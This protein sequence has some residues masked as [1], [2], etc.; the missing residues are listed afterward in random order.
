MGSKGNKS[1]RIELERLYGKECFIKKLKLREKY[2]GKFAGKKQVKKSIQR[3]NEILT[4]H[5]I[6]ERQNGGKATVENGAI[7]SA[8]NHR[9]FNEQSKEIQE[10]MNKAFQEYKASIRCA[11]IT[12]TPKEIKIEQ[13]KKINIETGAEVIEIKLEPMTEEEQAKYN[14]YKE[15]QRKKRY[16]KFGKNYNLDLDIPRKKARLDAEWQSEISRDVIEEMRY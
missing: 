10:E 4:Y 9:W 5:H 12:A 2:D 8:E 14:E 13:P 1:A 15:E 6:L 7:L 16:A 11:T 3:R